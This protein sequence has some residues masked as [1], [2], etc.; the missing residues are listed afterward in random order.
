M[1]NIVSYAEENLDSLAARPF[2]GVDSLILSWLSYYHLPPEVPSLHNWVGIPLRDLF[3]AETF[4]R[5]FRGVWDKENS[6]RLLTALA[7]SPRFRDIR[8]MGFTEQ[9]DPGREKQFAAL[10]VR[11]APNLTYVAFRGTDNSLVGWKEDFNMA[12]RHPV[13][14]QTEA[15]RYLADAA[16][17]CPGDLLVGGHSK[18]GNLAVYAAATVSPQIQARIRKVYSHDGP[19]FLETFLQSL[20]FLAIASKIEK[21]LPQSSIVGLLLDHREDCQV[22]RSSRLSFLQHDPFSWVLEGTDFSYDQLTADA[23]YWDRTLDDWLRRLSEEERERFVE[24]LYSILT[25]VDITDFAQF[26]DGWQKN[27]PAL[28]HAAANLDPDTRTFL[29]RIIRELASV[30]LHNF[31]E[32][33]RA[34]PNLPAQK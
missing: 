28:M 24:A 7:A 34:H 8:V 4:P 17:H 15:A 30:G 25:S 27:L 2:C 1:K 22:V 26:R 13:P 9:T 31:P 3:R 12:F 19:G 23:K 10:T 11:L 29:F 5:L 16:A 14:S 21:T 6:R 32:F 20:G 18:G 33:F